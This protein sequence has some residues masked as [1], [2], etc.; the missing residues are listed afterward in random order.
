MKKYISILMIVALCFCTCAVLFAGCTP[1][2]PPAPPLPQG[3]ETHDPDKEIADYDVYDGSVELKLAIGGY[4]WGPAVDGLVVKVDGKTFVEDFSKD[5]FRVTSQQANG[6]T[7]EVLEA[8][9]CTEQGVKTDKASNYFCV[10]FKTYAGVLSPFVYA[11]SVNRW[12]TGSVNFSLTLNEGQ[13][14]CMED[15]VEILR[16]AKFEVSQKLSYS[17]RVVPST[18]LLNKGSYSADGHTLTYGAYETEEMATDKGEN[19]LI[20]WLHGAGEGGTDVD[21]ALIGNDVTNLMEE[22]VQKYF[23]T[24]D[25]AGAYV[26]AVQTPTM[27]MDNGTG[28]YTSDGTSTYT[29][30]LMETIEYYVEQNGDVDLDRIYIGGCSNGGYMTMNM[31]IHYGDYFAAG[32]PVCEAYADSWIDETELSA[33]A[34]ANIWFTHSK[35]DGTVNPNTHTNATYIRLLQAGANVHYSM[36]EDIRGIDDPT[37]AQ[38]WGTTGNYNGHFSWIYTLSDRCTKVQSHEVTAINQL[39][40]NNDGGGQEQVDDYASLWAWIADQSR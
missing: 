35:N 8:Y 21:I 10:K 1:P 20:I 37:A 30:A 4:E 39:V 12:S 25:L 3:P 13:F 16:F 22:Q 32:Y 34:D 15:D 9:P 18:A 24:D 27:W 33:L 7:L 23:V 5:T 40:A 38:A 11:N 26:L 28:N 14:L 29:Q 19:A 31:L 6:K 2:E 36:F 17:E